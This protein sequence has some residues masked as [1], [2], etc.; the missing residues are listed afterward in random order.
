MLRCFWISTRPAILCKYMGFQGSIGADT[1]CL[2]PKVPA[3][4]YRLQSSRMT[5]VCCRPKSKYVGIGA[6]WQHL[7]LAYFQ[8]IPMSHSSS[9]RGRGFEVSRTASS[10]EPAARSAIRKQAAVLSTRTCSTAP[11]E[12]EF[13]H[14]YLYTC[15]QIYIFL[16]IYMST[17]LLKE[18]RRDSSNEGLG[19]R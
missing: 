18:R 15:L 19:G 8:K 5:H 3:Y 6:S 10:G 4:N 17:Y 9:T 16:C 11:I 14:T 2:L 12:L 7:F 13:Q 1:S